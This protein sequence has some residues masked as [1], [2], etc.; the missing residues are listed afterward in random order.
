MVLRTASLA[1]NKFRQLVIKVTFSFNNE[2]LTRVRSIANRQYNPEGKYWI[3]PLTMEN[4]KQ[5]REWGFVFQPDLLDYV[6]KQEQKQQQ[7][8]HQDLCIPGLKGAL[9]DFQKVCVAFCD[10]RDGN[11]LNADDMGLG[12]TIETLAWLQLHPELRPAIIVCPASAKLNWAR[13]ANKWMKSPKV[14]MLSGRTP[15]IIFHDTA[16]IVIVNYTI[17]PNSYEPYVD[18]QGRKKKR[19]IPRTGWVDYLINFQPKVLI[20]DEAQAIKNNTANQTL[21]V[22]KL[23]KSTPKCI[24]LTG[25]PIDNRPMDIYNIWSI[26]DPASCP[27]YWH[28][29]MTYCGAKNNGFGWDFSGF[30]NLPQLH[31]RM[32]HF[33]IRRMKRDVMTELPEKTRTVVPMELDNFREYKAAEDDFIK[34]IH[35]TK[36]K[37]AAEKAS[38]AEQLA[39]ISALKQLAIKGKMKQV[40]DWIEDYLDS[41]NKLVV[42]AYHAFIIDMLM[43]K[44]KDIAVK[45]DGSTPEKKRMESVDAFQTNPKVRLF[46]GNIIAA[47]TVITLT[48]ASDTATIE[49]MWGPGK[50]DQAEDRTCRIGQKNAVT[51]Y[52]LLAAGTIEERIA[53]IID[54]KRKIVNA[55]VDGE[56]TEMRSLLTE[57][58]KDYE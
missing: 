35:Q 46:V 40:F 14:Q 24:A 15:E 22:K 34:F 5:L 1:T 20:L 41:G 44:F 23:A 13:E 38:H 28:F 48:A 12:K 37:A 45:L 7:V 4:M 58:M 26:V 55:A 11:V 31:E 54:E 33:M 10:Q 16:E 32:K 49:L 36:G 47:G 6:K 51:A 25:T 30:S 56:E 50:H 2:D 29:A 19:E 18:A 21:A 9:R 3:I 43:N 27:T 52:Y 8:I 42:F 53:R 57:L 17:L 39:K